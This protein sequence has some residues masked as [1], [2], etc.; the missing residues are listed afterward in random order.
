[1]FIIYMTTVSVIDQ[2]N[3]LFNRIIS[4]INI[5][6]APAPTPAPVQYRYINGKLPVDNSTGKILLTSFIKKN[7]IYN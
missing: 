5:S 1:M 2:K 7:I 4:Y 6:A 3:K